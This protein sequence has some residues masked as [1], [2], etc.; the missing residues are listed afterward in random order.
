M[1]VCIYTHVSNIDGVAYVHM[2]WY[3]PVRA[4]LRGGPKLGM[5]ITRGSHPAAS[6]KHVL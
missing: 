3:T 1:Y 4:H 2:I 5:D 6:G